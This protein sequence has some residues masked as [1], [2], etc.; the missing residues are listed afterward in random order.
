MFPFNSHTPVD[1]LIFVSEEEARAYILPP[2]SRMILMDKDQPRFFIKSTDQYGQ[3]TLT[4]YVFTTPTPASPQTIET[5]QP[6]YVTR[7]E[8]ETFKASL[9]PSQPI[10]TPP[11]EV[12]TDGKST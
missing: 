3:S 9:A 4:P 7:E 12:N 5:P 8:F 2:S 1:N 10:T 11:Q 6:Q